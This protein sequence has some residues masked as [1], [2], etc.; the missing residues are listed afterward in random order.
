MN[1]DRS[2]MQKVVMERSFER[3]ALCYSD[4]FRDVIDDPER[5]AWLLHEAEALV[6]F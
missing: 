2:T 1:I 6:S 3:L 4:G 5:I